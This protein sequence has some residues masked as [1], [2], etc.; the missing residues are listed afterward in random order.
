M[1]AAFD[2]QPRCQ[3]HAEPAAASPRAAQRGAARRLRPGRGGGGDEPGDVGWMALRRRIRFERGQR[4][5][6]LGATGSAGRLA[7]Q[8]A[9]LCGA[10]RVI[11]AGRDPARLVSLA[12][13]GADDLVSLAG[14][15][16]AVPLAEVEQAWRES[17]SI[18]RRIVLVP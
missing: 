7:I 3:E 1:V 11:A 18:P 4:V 16:D 10:S 17:A 14:P 6:V 2:R 13:L 15:A 9:R 12:A 8:V 5:L